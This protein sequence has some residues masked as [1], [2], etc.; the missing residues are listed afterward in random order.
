MKKIEQFLKN[1]LKEVNEPFDPNAT[2]QLPSTRP[3]VRQQP[4]ADVMKQGR[5]KIDVGLKRFEETL[6]KQ[7]RDI[8]EIFGILNGP[9][10]KIP[11]DWKAAIA[12]TGLQ[13]N[14]G[15]VPNV[16][17]ANTQLMDGKIAFVNAGASARGTSTSHLGAPV[18]GSVP[19][20]R[21]TAT[22]APGQ[23]A[24]SAAMQ[25]SLDDRYD[26]SRYNEESLIKGAELLEYT[27][28]Q[29]I[30]IVRKFAQSSLPQ[31]VEPDA[32]I[33]L[34][35]PM[36]NNVLAYYFKNRQELGRKVTPQAFIKFML[37]ADP[38]GKGTE[39]LGP[40]DLNSSMP[41][42]YAIAIASY[43]P[44]QSHEKQV[45]SLR[46]FSPAVNFVSQATREDPNSQ[47]LMVI[48]A[49]R[50]WPEM[51]RLYVSFP[52]LQ[53]SFYELFQK[54][55]SLGA[56]TPQEKMASTYQRGEG[57][58]AYVRR[59]YPVLIALG[60]EH[61]LA[62]GA[63]GNWGA[64]SQVQPQLDR[65][66]AERPPT[67]PFGNDF[68]NNAST[69]QKTAVIQENEIPGFENAVHMALVTMDSLFKRL[70]KEKITQVG[71]FSFL[72]KILDKG[73]ASF[74]EESKNSKITIR[75]VLKNSLEKKKRLE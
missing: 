38:M 50:G 46:M 71:F 55:L 7:A 65:M 10:T 8:G 31:G 56:K 64:K 34:I 39:D 48:P 57:V 21:T 70:R 24:P 73:T 2:A 67:V 54:V 16:G 32:V 61:G 41:L 12:G 17:F 36:F 6:Q 15:Y 62:R 37:D 72:N 13:I 66:K 69:Q 28:K 29:S 49:P 3:I 51:T 26:S 40:K 43:L 4:V 45:Q 1:A 19:D 23:N 25:A 53:S 35:G 47:A 59:V 74:L 75:T 5:E 42:T 68:E 60:K 27:I 20:T 58:Q 52:F 22:I 30:I 44:Q 33:G 63:G 11:D 14:G 18:L 9:P